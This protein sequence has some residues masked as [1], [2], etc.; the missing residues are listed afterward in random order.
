MRR[1]LVLLI[2]AALMLCSCKDNKLTPT[3]IMYRMI[4]RLG[5]IPSYNIYFSRAEK[6]SEHYASGETLEKLYDGISP[7]DLCDSYAI[8]LSTDDLIYEIHIY[9]ALSR[10]KAEQTEEILRRRID[11]F[12]D[13]DIYMYNEE[14]YENV[15]S[16]ARIVQKGSYV[17]LLVTDKNNELEKLIN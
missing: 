10:V 7:E 11:L 5:V 12:G 3:D 1:F 9:K 2:T 4:E 17:Y 15:V 8:L 16:M 6:G 14:N 13:K